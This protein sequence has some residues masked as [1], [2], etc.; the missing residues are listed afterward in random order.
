MVIWFFYSF[1]SCSSS[2]SGIMKKN[3][4][5]FFPAWNITPQSWKNTQKSKWL[6][7]PK[8]C[9]SAITEFALLHNNYQISKNEGNQNFKLSR[10]AWFLQKLALKQLL[11]YL[12]HTVRC[13]SKGMLVAKWRFLT[14]PSP[15]WHFVIFSL[16]F[17]RSTFPTW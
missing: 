1:W 14:H 2:T 8:C 5:T 6:K 16:T 9:N 10:P 12:C 13:H 7:I 3:H 15:M 4:V 17:F 11:V